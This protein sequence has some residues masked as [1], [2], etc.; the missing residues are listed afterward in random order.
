MFAECPAGGTTSPPIAIFLGGNDD[1][2]DRD[3]PV[4]DIRV[5]VID[6]YD[7]LDELYEHTAGDH[8]HHGY[9]APD[10]SGV[11][12][13]AAQRRLVERLVDVG[14]IAPGS[15]VPDAGCGAG[16]TSVFLAREL[17]CDVDGITVS[18]RQI[19]RAEQK[20][21]EAGVAEATRLWHAFQMRAR[22]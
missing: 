13:E 6:Y 15:R 20:A 10:A 18:G 4:T 11:D 12:R 17:G 3:D 19:R 21:E 5:A 22:S 7:K 2:I 16:G 9:W 8:I 14:R 1:G